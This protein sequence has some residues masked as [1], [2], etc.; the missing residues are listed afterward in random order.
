[1][2]LD[3]V[4]GAAWLVIGS[5]LWFVR[6]WA[7]PAVWIAFILYELTLII[8]QMLFGRG[9]YE[10]GLLPVKIVMAVLSS[11]LLYY[12]LTRPRIRQAFNPD[13]HHPKQRS[14]MSYDSRPQS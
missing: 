7:R 13:A 5:G 14:R 12:A 6:P 3:G 10:R 2:L 1:M 11:L 8:Q 9:D 4:W